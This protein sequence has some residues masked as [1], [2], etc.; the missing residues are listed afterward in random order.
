M[1]GGL[2]TGP[3]TPDGKKR[4]A[5]VARRTLTDRHALRK[6]AHPVGAPGLL[7][8]CRANGVTLRVEG[9]RLRWWA[10]P[11][12]V[13]EQLAAQLST[14]ANALMDLIERER[15]PRQSE[16]H[17]TIPKPTEPAG[18]PPV[19]VTPAP[20]VPPAIQVAL[21]RMAESLARDAEEGR[22]RA[23]RIVQVAQ[24]YAEAYERKVAGE[25]E[26]RI[27]G[28]T[29]DT[30]EVD[31]AALELLELVGALP[32]LR[33]PPSALR[34]VPPPVATQGDDGAPWVRLRAAART[35]PLLIIGGKTSTSML[36]W[37]RARI[38]QGVVW[39]T[40]G[41]GRAAVAAAAKQVGSGAHVGA[42]VFG[43]AVEAWQVNELAN[44]AQHAGLPWEV[45]ASYEHAHVEAALDEIERVLRV[46]GTGAADGR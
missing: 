39:C 38:G 31:A 44:V 35:R 10:P 6:E 32:E 30:R 7:R 17:V 19:P 25:F 8:W 9:D 24:H 16:E 21:N 40:V 26:A 37:V 5:A 34:V 20:V 3:R 27:A 43:G 45:A 15:R 18:R 4:I 1:H 22:A 23:A 29:P 13:T 28:T 11:G 42:V 12:V 2:S 33:S 46:H 36:A 41:R 14:H